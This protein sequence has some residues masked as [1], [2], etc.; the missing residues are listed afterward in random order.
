MFS[1][2]N[3]KNLT[4]YICRLLYYINLKTKQQNLNRPNFQ[5]FCNNPKRILNWI[6]E[7]QRNAQIKL[8]TK[9]NLI[10][11]VEK[12]VEY[13][14]VTYHQKNTTRAEFKEQLQRIKEKMLYLKKGTQ[15]GITAVIRQEQFDKAVSNEKLDIKFINML[16]S[17]NCNLK[18]DKIV[19]KIINSA[20]SNI[21]DNNL[22]SKEDKS[23]ITRYCIA[24]IILKKLPVYKCR[25]TL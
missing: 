12:L 3:V 2:S 1:A 23:F 6:Q 22:L 5:A 7:F 17:A 10:K 8:R 9:A 24:V 15:K 13:L 16:N 4:A 20:Q 11:A 21:Q 18:K 14:D 19:A 25:P